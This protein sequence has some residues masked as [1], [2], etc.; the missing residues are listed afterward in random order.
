MPLLRIQIY[1]PQAHYRIPFSYQRRLTYPLPPYSTVLGF[2]CNVC[3]IND[4]RNELYKRGIQE[5]KIGISGR[6]KC[7]LTENLWFRNVSLEA[8]RNT[9]G[10]AQ[11]RFRNGQIGH[12]GGQSPIKIDVLQDVEITIY[13]YHLDFEYLNVI[14]EHLKNPVNRLGV[15][16]LGRSEDWIVYRNIALLSDESIEY[17]RRDGNYQFFFWIPQQLYKFNNDNVQINWDLFDGVNYTLATFSKIENYEFHYNN[18]GKRQ[19]DTI[20]AKL[21][22]GKILNGYCYFDK[23]LQLPVFLWGNI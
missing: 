22:D 6:F 16:H 4:Q 5:L 12:I 20:N 11:N 9:Y 8:H 3:G 1:Q 17:K 2:L 15:L 23:E 21:N 18:T 10:Y 13:L 14:Y 19:Y 7:K